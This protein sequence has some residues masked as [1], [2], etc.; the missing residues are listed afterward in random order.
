MDSRVVQP[1]RRLVPT[2]CPPWAVSGCWSVDGA[3]V[4]CGRRN[5]SG[6]DGV[7]EGG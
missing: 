3:R 4:Y 1:V 2:G 7:W 6:K 5:G